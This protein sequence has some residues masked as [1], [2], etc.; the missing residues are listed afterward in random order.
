[1][2]AVHIGLAPCVWL[3]RVCVCRSVY[4]NPLRASSYAPSYKSSSIKDMWKRL[5]AQKGMQ[6][7]SSSSGSTKTK[8]GS[9]V[10]YLRFVAGIFSQALHL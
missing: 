10:I 3:L 6:L 4:A 2:I 8:D 1:M 9:Q 7:E 5:K